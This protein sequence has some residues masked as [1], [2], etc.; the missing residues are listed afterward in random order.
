MPCVTFLGAVHSS[1]SHQPRILLLTRAEAPYRFCRFELRTR[2]NSGAIEHSGRFFLEKQFYTELPLT[3]ELEVIEALFSGAIST[4]DRP[5]DGELIN[6]RRPGA[7]GPIAQDGTV[8]GVL[9]VETDIHNPS[10]LFHDGAG[11]MTA[12]GGND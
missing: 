10:E 6:N 8:I 12:P 4:L 5:I 11:N 9:F 3:A 2:E 1:I 7:W